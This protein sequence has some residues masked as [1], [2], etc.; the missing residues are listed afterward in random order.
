MSNTPSPMI[1]LY[2]P[3][4]TL[5]EVPYERMHEALQ[6]GAKIAVHMTAPDGTEGYVPGDKANDAVKAGGKIVPLNVAGPALPEK[7][8]FFKAAGGTLKGMLQMPA[9]Q[10]PYPGM[11]QEEKAAAAGGAYEQDVARQQAGYS[12]AYRAAA[13]L[14]QAVGADVPGMERAAAA[15][16]EPGVYGHAFGSAAPIAAAEVA[17]QAIPP[18]VSGIRSVIGK[19]IPR[20]AEG[21]LAPGSLV[22]VMAH[23]G[24]LPEYAINK[25]FPESPETVAA[26]NNF[27]Q[28]KTI[29]EAHEAAIAKNAIIDARAARAKAIADKQKALQA[30]IPDY[31]APGHKE[32]PLGAPEYPGPNMAIP[33]RLTA[34]QQEFLRQGPAK[35]SDLATQIPSK[36][37]SKL[38]GPESPAPPINKTYVSYPGDM[39]VELAKK[40]DL[41]AVRELIRN[42]RGINISNIPGVRYLI[43]Q[44]RTGRVYGGPTE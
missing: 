17:H 6:A 40:G 23:P 32:V 16:D 36:G 15:G 38:Y 37:G 21:A 14:A 41:N 39:L 22:D 26:R 18:A 44:G 42:P 25:L 31:V 7:E 43:E 24:K 28:A 29:T 11:G 1:S 3:D 33:P 2:A 10:N 35:L 34:A 5:G 27:L 8:G 13:P 4:G 12:P 30:K 19:A 9:G 20:T